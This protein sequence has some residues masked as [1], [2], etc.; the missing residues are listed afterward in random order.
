[1]SDRLPTSDDEDEDEDGDYSV[2]SQSQESPPRRRKR[3]AKNRRT[4]KKCRT[5]KC[6]QSE[7]EAEKENGGGCANKPFPAGNGGRGKAGKTGKAATVAAAADR[8]TTKVSSIESAAVARVTRGEQDTVDDRDTCRRTRGGASS[9]NDKEVFGWDTSA[10]TSTKHETSC[11]DARRPCPSTDRR[12]GQSLLV[13][14]KPEKGNG[15]GGKRSSSRRVGSR[16]SYRV[17]GIVTANEMAAGAAPGTGTLVAKAKKETFGRETGMVVAD[18]AGCEGKKA[19]EDDGLPF[20]Q[21]V[22]ELRRFV[23]LEGS[24]VG[25]RRCMWADT[26]AHHVVS[27]RLRLTILFVD[28]VSYFSCLFLLLPPVAVRTC[29]A[30]ICGYST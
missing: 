25:H 26:F 27:R 22:D 2:S 14:S 30:C 29:Q 28:M 1:M 3:P 24:E 8:S 7:P 20:V 17:G 23:R 15:D 11:L 10:K 16:R 21:S 5:R 9:I 18:D 6:N 13:A 19:K 12:G 4:A